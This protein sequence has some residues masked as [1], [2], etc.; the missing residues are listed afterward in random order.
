[1]TSLQKNPK[2]IQI[3]FLTEDPNA[4]QS[5][6][7]ERRYRVF[8]DEKNTEVKPAKN[9]QAHKCAGLGCVLT[10]TCGRYLRPAAKNQRW[11]AFYT[12]AGARCN[13]FEVINF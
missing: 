7:G 5:E 6:L 1:M 3:V 4:L 10:S 9:G 8:E 13:D 12:L 11:A 2:D